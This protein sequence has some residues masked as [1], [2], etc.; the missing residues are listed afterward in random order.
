M[1]MHTGVQLQTPRGPASSQPGNRQATL[2]NLVACGA[3]R[4]GS[5]AVEWRMLDGTTSLVMIY[6]LVISLVATRERLNKLEV[7]CTN[8]CR[9]T[10]GP[11]ESNPK[12]GNRQWQLSCES[13]VVL[14]LMSRSEC[15]WNYSLLSSWSRVRVPPVPNQGNRSSVG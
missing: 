12:P 2:V 4:S 8:A 10:L 1:R 9:T 6:G 7:F 5:T 15:R 3:D 11:R 13:L 14:F